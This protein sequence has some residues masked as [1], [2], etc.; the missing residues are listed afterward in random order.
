M[1]DHTATEQPPAAPAVGARADRGVRPITTGRRLIDVHEGC[2]LPPMFVPCDPGTESP[3]TPYEPVPVA[4][5][6]RLRRA[7]AVL[8]LLIE[9]TTDEGRENC[10]R[11]ARGILRPNSNS[12]TPP[13]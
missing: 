4:E 12:Q 6:R 9:A 2:G 8:R 10:L 5:T 3:F 11:I 1:T 7:E 13:V